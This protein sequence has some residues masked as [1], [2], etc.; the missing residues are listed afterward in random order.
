MSYFA[1]QIDLKKRCESLQ[2][3]TF[4]TK[5]RLFGFLDAMTE[6]ISLPIEDRQKRHFVLKSVEA[7]KAA[8]RLVHLAAF[9]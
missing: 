6:K 8:V 5:T 4:C 7:V 9:Q 1:C 3:L 2:S